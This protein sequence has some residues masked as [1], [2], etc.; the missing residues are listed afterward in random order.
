MTYII[1]SIHLFNAELLPIYEL[2][3]AMKAI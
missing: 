3:P 2:A 1:D